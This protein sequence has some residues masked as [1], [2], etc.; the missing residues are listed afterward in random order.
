MFMSYKYY[1]STF[2]F[3]IFE[4]ISL[5]LT[6]VLTPGQGAKSNKKSRQKISCEL[7]D[8]A[9]HLVSRIF[10]PFGREI[11]NAKLSLLVQSDVIHHFDSLLR[12]Y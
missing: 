3:T 5:C 1:Y 10:T 9:V 7:S 6:F 8:S 11:A 4:G 12:I 2:I